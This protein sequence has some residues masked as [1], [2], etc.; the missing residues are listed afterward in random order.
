[1]FPDNRN[2][3]N[4]TTVQVCRP[5]LK[6]LERWM[7]LHVYHDSWRVKSRILI[8]YAV[9]I[10]LRFFFWLV[11]GDGQQTLQPFHWCFCWCES[12]LWWID[13]CWSDSKHSICEHDLCPDG[14]DL[15]PTSH[16]VSC[17]ASRY[18]HC[19]EELERFVGPW[20]SCCR[21]VLSLTTLLSFSFLP[22]LNVCVAW[23]S[24][25]FQYDFIIISIWFQLIS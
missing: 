12:G 4:K 24:M 13:P 25:W 2:K 21:L 7:C 14:F 6:M 23:I 11:W 20:V 22:W 16:H 9:R 10:C 19:F 8:S 3:N 18:R 15:P 5:R 17:N 1:M